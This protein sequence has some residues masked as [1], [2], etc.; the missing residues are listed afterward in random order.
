MDRIE[1]LRNNTICSPHCPKKGRAT[2]AFRCGYL[3]ALGR[4][5]A[6]MVNSGISQTG[7]HLF[8]TLDAGG[9]YVAS[10]VGWVQG[11]DRWEECNYLALGTDPGH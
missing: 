10:Q 11:E 6:Q 4:G 2:F 9:D 1:D 5:G 7:K 3:R 8:H